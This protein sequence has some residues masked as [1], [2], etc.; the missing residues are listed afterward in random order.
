MARSSWFYV[1]LLISVMLLVAALGKGVNA[2]PVF[3][4]RSVGMHIP[5]SE[6]RT[7]ETES[8]SIHF[9]VSLEPTAQYVARLAEQ[10]HPVLQERLQW[11]PKHKTVVVI[12]DDYDTAN[13]WA[14]PLPFNAVRLF[15]FTPDDVQQLES[16]SDWQALLF[17]HE[18][19]HIL[20]LDKALGGPLQLRGWFGR[21]AG[22]LPL[23]LFPNAFQPLFMI[24]G[25]AIRQESALSPADGR[26][27]NSYYQML[28]RDEVRRGPMS[29]SSA[30]VSGGFSY[31]YGAYFYQFL[32]AEYGE[33]AINALIDVYSRQVIP[34]RFNSVT[35][36]VLGVSD[37][38][39]W[40]QYQQW[41]TEHYMSSEDATG[42]WQFVDSAAEHLAFYTGLNQPPVVQGNLVWRLWHDGH[43]QYQL[44]AYNQDYEVEQQ[45]PVRMPGLFSVNNEGEVVIS[46]A[47]AR[48]ENRY[49]ADLYVYRNG[50]WRQLTQHARFT[51]AHWW[52]EERL[53][54]KRQ[55]RGISE[56]VWL[57]D[58]GKELNTLWRASDGVTL[59]R[60]A[61]H[62]QTETLV[63][64]LH[65]ADK[66]WQLYRWL[67]HEQAW[68]TL[69]FG[70]G[71][72][73]QPAISTDG[74][75]VV[76]ISDQGGA[77]N[78]YQLSLH[79]PKDV[80]QLTAVSS[81]MFNPVLAHNGKLWAEYYHD[82]T[83]HLV[84][85]DGQPKPVATL[86]D[87][88]QQLHEQGNDKVAEPYPVLPYRSAQTLKPTGWFAGWALTEETSQLALV[89]E[90]SDALGRHNYTLL[91]GGDQQT[92]SPIGMLE[93][94]YANRY[95][96][97]LAREVEHVRLA[98][99]AIGSEA[100]LNFSLYR[101]NVLGAFADDFQLHFGL[102]GERTED[103][104]RDSALTG[105]TTSDYLQVAG[106]MA[107]YETTRSFYHNVVP[108]A[109][110]N[111]TLSAEQNVG[112]SDYIGAVYRLRWQENIH[113]HNSHVLRVLADAS[114]GDRDSKAV[115]LGGE[116]AQV[117]MLGAT[118]YSLRGYAEQPLLAG[119]EVLRVATEWRFPLTRQDKNWRTFPLGLG[120]VHGGLF[121]DYGLIRGS[122][123]SHM[124]KNLNGF[125]AELVIEPIIA[126]AMPVPI[127]LGVAHGTNATF[128]STRVYLNIG[129]S[130]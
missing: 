3:E 103:I 57:D 14:T 89:T 112:A 4:P 40:Q 2:N 93:Y 114:R 70:A 37:T 12:T 116:T 46:Q 108:A 75:S 11:A 36:N 129:A 66:G 35:R 22:I 27:N 48:A 113:L 71:I 106:A 19:T 17:E 24:E 51:E 44:R 77:Y 8:F 101:W 23:A 99:N 95:Q 98:D 110:R 18:Y 128:G 16:F 13:G 68:Q 72:K 65:T 47:K 104:S 100:K 105:V 121:Y 111:I 50:R 82:R 58:Q 61:V 67:G 52:G 79:N 88:S 69:T 124:R 94:S 5:V 6:W 87:N 118:R 102:V 15:M 26:L 56:L 1:G 20:H 109:G 64:A 83:R 122:E 53:L 62:A 32:A 115:R 80:Q 39:L 107:S 9:P 73:Q 84:V 43:R 97:S 63:A 74:A 125:G 29:L 78:V 31:L 59:G 30:S 123:Y 85:F 25:L 86:W 34:F 33:E 126:Y 130:F 127:T 41:L 55:V 81:G 92:R 91:A 60:F 7:I 21:G 42:H 45:I 90:G 38:V 120:R 49:L 28:I 117:N 96:L 10:R 54:A 119:D 76:Y